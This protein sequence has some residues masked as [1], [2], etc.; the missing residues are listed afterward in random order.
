MLVAHSVNIHIFVTTTCESD[1]VIRVILRRSRAC[2]H[3]IRLA[4][5]SRACNTSEG[6]RSQYFVAISAQTAISAQRSCAL[7][8]PWAVQPVVLVEWAD[9]RAH[10]SR[11]VE[12]VQI[13]ADGFA[14][15]AI[16]PAAAARWRV[17][18]PCSEPQHIRRLLLRLEAACHD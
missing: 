8:L 12:S 3:S 5:P 13:L 4:T 1:R 10:G 6:C 14:G 15:A 11:E 17:P 7:G 16:P 2:M 9:L 18:V